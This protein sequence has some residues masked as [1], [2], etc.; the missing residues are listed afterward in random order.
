MGL[1]SFVRPEATTNL[2]ANPS[3]E[4]GTTG[5]AV[6]GGVLT[7]TTNEQTKGLYSLN[8]A[9]GGI[10]YCSVYYDIT[11]SVATEY[12]IS[13]DVKGAS[14]I[15]Y[16]IYL[17]DTV[18]S[19]VLGS[20][21]TF[22]GDG[23]WHRYVLTATTGANAACSIYIG[24]NNSADTSTVYIDALQIEQK[25]YAT[26]YCDGDQDG[27]LWALTPHASTSSRSAQSSAGGRVIDLDSAGYEFEVRSSLG[28]GMPPIEIIDTLPAQ[29]DGGDFQ[30]QIARPRDF[31]LVGA[32]PGTDRADYHTNRLNLIEAVNPHRL[33]TKQPIQLR[34]SV[35][36]KS[37]A[38]DGYYAGG[39]EKNQQ[40]G[41]TV[42][43]IALR[44]RAED[45]LFRA[46]TGHN[47]G[48]YCGGQGVATGDVQ[49]TVANADY[50][51]QRDPDGNWQ[52]L[53]TGMNDVV[54]ALAI[55]PDG[56]LY[57][58]GNF[59]LA[60]GVAC[61]RVAKW[62]GSTWAPLGA[63]VDGIVYDLAFGPDGTLYAGGA[64]HN[65]GGAG[66]NHI[67][68]WNGAAW[69]N[70]GVGVDDIVLAL[71]IAD[72]GTLY[73]GGQFLNAGGAGANRVA[74]WDGAAWSALGAGVDSNVYTL[75]LGGDGTLYAGGTFLNA[76]GAGANRVASW[77]G[78]NWAALGSG[79]NSDV[80][81]V[82]VTPDE[83]V[84][85]GGL[86]TTPHTYLTY[87]NGTKFLS[88]G[89]APSYQIR[90]LAIDPN[91][92]IYAGMIFGSAV[93]L[94]AGEWVG[95]ETDLPDVPGPAEPTIWDIAIDPNDG[96]VTLGFD[97]SGNALV[98]GVSTATNNGTANA[99]PIFKAVGPG[100]IYTLKNYTTDEEISFNLELLDGETATLDL[101]PSEKT[102]STTFRENI[103]DTIIEGSDVETFHLMP[104]ANEI[105]IYVDDATA[106]AYLLWQEYHW[107][108]D[109]VAA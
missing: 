21:L 72:D 64:F 28:V 2:I 82:M 102:F 18:A 103:I 35:S 53:G 36:E 44:F 46:I 13:V 71:A 85:V 54:Y 11:L 65:A 45:P 74:S 101:R 4:T 90:S 39:L 16:R 93:K 51:F 97:S 63:G 48:D 83:R 81:K 105:S 43:E 27:C 70:L 84:Y 47:N 56:Y 32:M 29:S 89:D 7:R 5:Y 49:D 15:P 23:E 14:G 42:E 52:A 61:N 109:G 77:D 26:T 104:G 6:T 108:L 50:I 94:I 66:A 75:A 62:D 106:E 91:G 58:G 24:K 1:W 9:M 12:T 88:P 30:N 73:A 68:S 40:A 87:W 80:R 107:S 76:G 57:A 99:C 19:V 25:G 10:L 41:P 79:T 8:M 92:I 37:V 96:T 69:S 3:A 86:F 31:Q 59:T 67:A 60:G 33:A 78:A 17:W 95:I 98:A 22:T 34:Y 20:V 100:N 38:I 55:G